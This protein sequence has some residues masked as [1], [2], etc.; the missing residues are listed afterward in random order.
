MKNLIFLLFILA[1]IQHVSA[2]ALPDS[3]HVFHESKTKVSYTCEGINLTWRDITK[4]ASSN[5]EAKKELSIATTNYKTGM[6]LGYASAIGAGFVLLSDELEYETKTAI[7]FACVGVYIAAIPLRRSSIK[8]IDNAVAIL[9][10]DLHKT[11]ALAPP[12]LQFGLTHSGI[13]LTVQF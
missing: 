2:Q 7:T 4:Y 6:F 8:H 1:G 10:R 3:I 11:G 13:G 12:T 9:N 5:P